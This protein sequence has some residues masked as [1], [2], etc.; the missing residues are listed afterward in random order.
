MARFTIYRLHKRRVRQS[1]STPAAAVTEP[2][3][4]TGLSAMELAMESNPG[5]STSARYIPPAGDEK[6]AFTVQ[7]DSPAGVQ[8]EIGA[9]THEPRETPSVTL[10]ELASGAATPIPMTG[11]PAVPARTRVPIMAAPPAA[12]V[13]A[14]MAGSEAKSETTEPQEDQAKPVP[15]SSWDNSD[16][17]KQVPAGTASSADVEHTPVDDEEA[18]P[19]LLN[20]VS[21][22]VAPGRR[23]SSI[24]PVTDSKPGSEP[25]TPT[26][27]YALGDEPTISCEYLSPLVLRKE[28]ERAI[29]Q[30]GGAYLADPHLSER[31]PTLFWN[32]HWHFCVQHLPTD[33]LPM[34]A[35]QCIPPSAPR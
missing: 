22:P 31:S 3:S 23:P 28:L 19:P 1:V 17:E 33:F 26:V 2:A 12:H 30:E 27:E 29:D 24:T 11:A 8:A 25:V 32:L 16:K 21:A 13:S 10:S 34:P 5:V 14:A 6:V 18:P 35:P 15:Q 7:I 4:G 9:G 20:S